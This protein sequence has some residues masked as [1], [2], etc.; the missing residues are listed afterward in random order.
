MSTHFDQ[1]VI[2]RRSPKWSRAVVWSIV[3]VTTFT[4][5][6]AYFAKLEEAVSATGQLE[7]QGTVREVRVPLNGV[8]QV[9]HVQDG[10]RV[11][12]GALLITLDQKTAEAQV[13]SLKKIRD[14][15]RAETLFYRQEMGS[16]IPDGTGETPEFKIPAE[17]LALTKSRA[18]L[19]AETALY[20]AQLN[21]S[22]T[23]MSLSSEQALRLQSS[24]E[25]VKTRQ[26]T[27]QLET[28]Q[29]QKQLAQN[30]VQLNTAKEILQINQ[31]IFKDLDQVAR[32]GG[33][34]RIQY[35][36]QQQEVKTSQ[37]RVQ[38]LQ[39]EQGRL[40]L[41][42]AQ[43][44]QKFQNTIALSNQDLLT[45]VADNEKRIAQ[46]DGE[47]NKAIVENEKKIAEIDSQ[48]KQAEQ[49][50]QYQEVRAPVEGTVFDLKASGPG[51][52]ATTTEPVLK[53]VPKDAL[54][55][56]LFIPN[57]DIGFIKTGLP[58][59]VRVDSYPFSEFGDLKG[60][61]ESIG[62]D[63]L[64]PTQVRQFYSFPVTVRLDSMDGLKDN[65]RDLRL[66]SGMSVSANIKVRQRSVMSIF[67]DGFTQ[68]VDSFKSVR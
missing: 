66:Q 25:E 11:S 24:L 39:E 9:V 51:Y 14:A 65:G 21:G 26:R 1:P 59:D 17:T 4:V 48:L 67:V 35:L 22:T 56:E 36:R 32:E 27:A 15:L 8:V 42:I 43:A 44:Q 58:V 38:Q 60:V 41:A 52:V 54:K 40:R 28:E 68:K 7:P 34:A 18:A 46:I 16:S 23:G 19:I 2:L 55:V 6:W 20:R 47:L 12:K 50:L 33:L 37:A 62:S 31:G 63:A 29:L 13:K 49:T 61:V 10:D 3:G 53:V 64:P 30:Q 45:K 57:K 5:L